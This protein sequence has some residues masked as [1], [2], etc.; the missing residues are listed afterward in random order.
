MQKH[1]DPA[2]SIIAQFGGPDVVSGITGRSVSRV[3]RW[4]YPQSRGGTGG[5][6]PH[7]EAMKLLDHA[8][9]HSL[10]VTADDFLQSP[11]PAED[12]RAAS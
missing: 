12:L 8:R 3:Y 2:K 5:V 9:D 1:M 10:D 7:R 6:I 11:R 4:M